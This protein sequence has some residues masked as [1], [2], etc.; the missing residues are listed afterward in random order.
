MQFSIILTTNNIM[1]A[2]VIDDENS[3]FV[4]KFEY[5]RE[6]RSSIEAC[7]TSNWVNQRIENRE[8]SDSIKKWL[9][10]K[11]VMPMVK[12]KKK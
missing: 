8:H 4:E 12:A 1:Y 2:L 3:L 7:E 11:I 10:Q 5:N 6:V 9:L